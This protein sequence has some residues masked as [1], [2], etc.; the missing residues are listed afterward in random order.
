MPQTI[1]VFKSPCSTEDT[2]TMLLNV[3]NRIGKVRR[4]DV[5][6]AIIEG[7]FSFGIRLSSIKVDFFLEKDS[8]EC[9][10][11]AVVHISSLMSSDWLQVRP[12]PI[13]KIWDYFLKSLSESYPGLDFGVRLA[14]DTFYIATA[15]NMS[16]N[17]KQI[18]TA[19]TT[20]G[21][22]L[23]GFLLGGFMFGAPGAIV[24]GLSGKTRTHGQTETIL[25]KWVIMRVILSNGR[26]T[27]GDVKTDSK[28]Y[29][30]MMVSMS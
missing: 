9:K 29:N 2:F 1:F 18:Y 3:I 12:Q 25:S 10:V 15:Q 4:Y 7:G 22:S 6:R 17:T 5:S 14:S 8:E 24:G 21:T 16:G 20:G 27:Q 11:R 19:R 23:A 30:E 26:I 13:D 28:V